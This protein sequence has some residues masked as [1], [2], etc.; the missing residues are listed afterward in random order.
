MEKG[1]LIVAVDI[2]GRGES[3]IR[4]GIVSIGV[5]VGR[6]DGTVI[7]TM[8]WD[9]A[10]YAGQTMDAKCM[11]EFWSK[12]GDLLEVLQRNA[13]FPELAIRSFRNYLD[14][15]TDELYLVSDAPTYDFGFINYYLDREGLPLLQFDKSGHFRA[16][17]DADSYARGRCGYPVT[18]QWISNSRALEQLG[19]ATPMKE[20]AEGR[21]HMPEEDAKKIFA[22]HVAI[23]RR[24]LY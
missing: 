21:A 23:I 22:T 10:P 20:E 18:R 6:A 14:A 1:P 12:Q 13:S 16:L 5:C 15:F 19:I 4:N 9:I 7:E 24:G 8:R 17:H 3:A 2:E 11:D